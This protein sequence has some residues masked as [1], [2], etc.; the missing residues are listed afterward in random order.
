M[1]D[2]VVFPWMPA[3]VAALGAAEAPAWQ[4][5]A[6]SGSSSPCRTAPGCRE[7][8]SPC[9]SGR[10][11][12]ARSRAGIGLA[13]ALVRPARSGW[14][15]GRTALLRACAAAGVAG[16]IGDRARVLANALRGAGAVGRLAPLVA[17][18]D[19]SLAGADTAM[20]GQAAAMPALGAPVAPWRE[21]I[22]LTRGALAGLAEAYSSGATRS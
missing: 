5:V 7:R 13:A 16:G 6:G 20:A 15:L 17:A 19:A 14:L 8:R 2:T 1:L 3:W 21:R 4:V 12:H 9:R 11:R 18:L 10:A 22:A